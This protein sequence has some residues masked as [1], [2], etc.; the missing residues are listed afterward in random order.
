MA[1]AVKFYNPEELNGRALLVRFIFSDI[2]ATSFRREQAFS[3]DGGK[4]WEP[5]WIAAFTRA[6]NQ[7]AEGTVPSAARAS[8]NFDFELGRWS[9]HT[10]RLDDPLGGPKWLE[11]GASTHLIG[12]VWAGRAALAEVELPGSKPALGSGLLRTY[13]PQTKQWRLHSVDRETG[14]VSAPMVGEFKNGRGEFY[15]QHDTRGV[16]V[17]ARVL[18]LDITTTSFRVQQAYSLD[19]GTSWKPNVVSTFTR[20]GP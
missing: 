11:S 3:D 6:T 5:N 8:T 14:R 7:S 18:Y 15:G 9:V 19:G 20:S 16:T 12:R 13:N 2:T 17:L 4:S 10:R 1:R